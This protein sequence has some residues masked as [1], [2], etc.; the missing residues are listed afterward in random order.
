MPKEQKTA[1]QFDAEE[2]SQRVKDIVM[3]KEWGTAV[4]AQ[5]DTIKI[6][7]VRVGESNE[8]MIRVSGQ[9]PGNALK[10]VTTRHLD[11]FLDLVRMISNNEGNL[12]IK[13]M[14]LRN[15]LREDTA[16]AGIVL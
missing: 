11:N 3:K 13:L 6:E 5:A 15:M 10:I 12:L 4:L 16:N 2:F 1:P 14:T 9:K 8:M 7:V